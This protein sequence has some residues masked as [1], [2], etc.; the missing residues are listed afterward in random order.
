MCMRHGCNP[1]ISFVIFPEFVL[2]HFG[3]T[4]PKYIDTKYLVDATASVF[5]CSLRN[6]AAVSSRSEDGVWL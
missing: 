3:F 1:L 4:L 6:F 5:A 2:C